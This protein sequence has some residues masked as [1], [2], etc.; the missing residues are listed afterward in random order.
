VL[1]G[2]ID[3]GSN[4]IRMA[5]YEIQEDHIDMLMKKK[6]TVGLASYL[7]DGDLQQAG[8]DRTVEILKEFRSFLESLRIDRVAAFATAA[9]RSAGN[10]PK[11]LDEIEQRTG[12]LVDVISGSEEAELGFL[13]ATHSLTERSGILADIGGASTEVVFFRDGNI[14]RKT[15]L[16]MGSLMLHTKHGKDLLSSA[17]ECGRMREDAENILMEATDLQEVSHPLICGIGGTFKG[18]KALYNAVFSED[19]SRS[20]SMPVERI[21][22][23]IQRFQRNREFGTEEVILLMK[24]VPERMH[25]L[26]PGLVIADVLARRFGSETILYSD[27]GVREG[28]IYSKIMG[29]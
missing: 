22:E 14:L 8:I 18:A 23:L 19:S 5:I 20:S 15:S 24:T 17:E 12:I 28:Y 1:Q 29:R 26:V 6:H 10:R 27:S 25:T 9:L 4:T 7:K 21:R 3:I 11:V 16:P 2:M 13:G